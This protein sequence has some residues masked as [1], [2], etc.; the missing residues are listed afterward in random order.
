MAI[1]EEKLN[2]LLGKFVADFGAAFHAGLVVIGERLGLYKALA[3]GAMTSAEL[4]ERTGTDER[5][6][7]EWLNSQA[8]GEYVQYDPPTG[9]YSLSEE[10]AFALADEKSP[11]YLPGAFLLAVSALRA[12]PQI[13]ERFRT[14]EGFGWHEH[15]HGLFRGTELFF[16]PG[17]AANLTSSWI[18]SLDGVEAKLKSGAKVADVGCG[19]GASTI[20]M[21][22]TYPSSTFIGYDYHDGSIEMARQRAEEAGVSD[23]VKFEVARA[24]DY[25][26]T[27]Y[28]FVAFFDCLH[29]MGDPRGAA[30]HVRESLAPDGTWMV[31][32][33]FAGDKV[34]DN[35]NPV[36][37]IYYSASTLLCTPASK[38]QEVG[39]AL[40]AQAGEA[41]LREVV[42]GG[43]FGQFRRA[44]ETP[45]NIVYEAKP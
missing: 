13:T 42:T 30:A 41:R 5:Y 43:G 31:V 21:A 38:S 4:A 16:R 11:A 1:N 15:D 10:Q 14:G 39:L 12:V 29:D 27:G 2:Q 25:P 7:R 45:F 6:V 34:E 9:R 19:L 17:Y 28:D 22:Q 24:K 40:G 44:A 37:R 20:L 18:P 36:G 33:P 3:A 26:G 35:L 32:E 23:R 8:A